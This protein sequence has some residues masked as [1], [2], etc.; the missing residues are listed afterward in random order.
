MLKTQEEYSQAIYNIRLELESWEN[1]L[2]E[3]KADCSKICKQVADES[4]ELDDMRAKVSESKAKLIL[5]KKELCQKEESVN[6][7]SVQEAKL[8]ESISYN[9]I[10]FD[11]NTKTFDNIISGRIEEIKKLDGVIEDKNNVILQKKRD[12]Q[13]LDGEIGIKDNLCK[14]KEQCIAK[15]DIL[16]SQKNE[17]LHKIEDNILEQK[18]ISVEME[19]YHKNLN[20]RIADTEKLLKDKLSSLKIL[21]SD[22][23]QKE[24]KLEDIKQQMLHL[25][26]K[27]EQLKVKEEE[28]REYYHKAGLLI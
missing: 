6:K 13:S 16:I 12:I 11:N 15:V 14:E 26:K 21:T 7:L 2:S 20:T 25:V 28:I 24:D 23:K 5:L 4:T 22:V 8:L 27:E 18:A 3:I 1:K 17:A 9:T 10:E 19:Q